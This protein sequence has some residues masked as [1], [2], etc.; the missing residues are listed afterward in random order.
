MVQEQLHDL[1]VAARGGHV[2]RLRPR[3]SVATAAEDSAA[4]T[5]TAAALEADELF[6]AQE[7]LDDRGV[8]VGR[9]RPDWVAAVRGALDCR[10][11]ACR[12]RSA[13]HRP[14]RP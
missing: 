13:S 4:A 12:R 8:A 7:P 14:T 3:L 6:E 9:G 2:Q 11:R 1:G 10:R 5:E